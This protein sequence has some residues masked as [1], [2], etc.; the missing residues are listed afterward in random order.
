MNIAEVLVLTAGGLAALT[1]VRGPTFVVADTGA[2][3]D[4]GV[5]FEP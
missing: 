1:E 4:D 2:L 3:A 5:T